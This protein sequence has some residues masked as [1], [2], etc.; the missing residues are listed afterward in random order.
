[1]G[2]II[3]TI[4]RNSNKKIWK[5]SWNV[6]IK[7]NQH[8]QNQKDNEFS[9][10]ACVEKSEIFSNGSEKTNYFHFHSLKIIIEDNL[11]SAFWRAF[12]FGFSLGKNSFLFLINVGVVTTVCKLR[13]KIENTKVRDDKCLTLKTSLILD[14]ENQIHRWTSYL[15]HWFCLWNDTKWLHVKIRCK[16]NE[17]CIPVVV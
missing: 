14:L 8:H 3:P 9:W 16:Q 1:M 10:V 17:K 13:L 6:M 11:P 5:N 7:F 12:S 4:S 15:L 2:H